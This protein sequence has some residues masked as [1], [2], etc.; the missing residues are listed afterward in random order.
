MC[1]AMLTK[2]LLTS[3]LST[4]GLIELTWRATKL[5]ISILR[6]ISA[7]SFTFS[8]ILLLMLFSQSRPAKFAFLYAYLH[9]GRKIISR[10]WFFSGDNCM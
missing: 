5:K 9:K 1:F 3:S 4:L 10:L 8:R 6:S 2:I 7:F